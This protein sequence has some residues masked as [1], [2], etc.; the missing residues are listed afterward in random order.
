MFDKFPHHKKY[1]P[2]KFDQRLITISEIEIKLDDVPKTGEF[3]FTAG[4]L[5]IDANKKKDY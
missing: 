3:F 2:N 4:G 5:E 1:L